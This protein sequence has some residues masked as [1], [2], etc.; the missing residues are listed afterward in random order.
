MSA[1]SDLISLIARRQ[2]L[3]DYKQ[4]HWTG[5]FAEYLDLVKTDPKVTRTAYQRLY[6]MI[7]SKGTEEI[8]VNKEKLL[9]YKFFEDPDCNGEDA[10]FGLERTLISLVNVFKSAAQGYGI[11]RRVLLL[12]GPVGSSKSTHRPAAQEGARTVL[13]N[14]RTAGCTPRLEG[15]RRRSGRVHWMPDARGAAAPD[16]RRA[17]RRDRLDAERRGGPARLRNE[18]R[19]GPLPVLPPDV[20]RAAGAVRRRLDRGSSR[21][22]A[23]RA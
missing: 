16:P 11:E 3:E 17:P 20:Q 7:L 4:K 8:V 6:D 14:R 12:H 1:G 21:T 9:Q 19:G 23:S 18:D 2:N 22:S 15:G 10:I 5:G 13:E